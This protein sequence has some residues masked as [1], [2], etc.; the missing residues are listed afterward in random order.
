MGRESVRT[1]ECDNRVQVRTGTGAKWALRDRK[2]A[3]PLSKRAD[4]ILEAID[5]LRHLGMLEMPREPRPLPEC[6]RG[7]IRECSLSFHPRGERRSTR[8]LK[9]GTF[10]VERFRGEWGPHPGV[11]APR[12]APLLAQPRNLV[13]DMEAPAE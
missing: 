9:A 8:F 11:R 6:V 4:L 7:G 2:H 13:P 1:C 12:D 10:E 5:L 3:P